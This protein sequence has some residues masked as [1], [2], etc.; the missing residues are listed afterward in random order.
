MLTKAVSSVPDSVIRPKESQQ[1]SPVVGAIM[2]TD[3]GMLLDAP[4]PAS[5]SSASLS[6]WTSSSGMMVMC[7]E[8]HERSDEDRRL[9]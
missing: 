1:A 5:A 6:K 7:C 2:Y 3:F 8:Q 9:P 4:C